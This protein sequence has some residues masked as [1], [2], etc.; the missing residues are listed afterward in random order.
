LLNSIDKTRVAFKNDENEPENNRSLQPSDYNPV[1]N[2]N[3]QNNPQYNIDH[4]LK[5][6][7]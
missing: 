7:K 1:L 5:L 3:F 4:H 2:N 6:E